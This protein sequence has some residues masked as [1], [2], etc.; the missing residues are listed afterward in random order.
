MCMDRPGDWNQA[1]MELGAR[2]CKPA[3]LCAKCPIQ[4]LCKAHAKGLEANLPT[5][6]VLSQTIRLE[7]I[8][9]IPYYNGLFGLKQIP[10]GRWWHGMWEFPRS[11]LTADLESISSLV[12]EGDLEYA[13]TIKYQVTNHKIQMRAELHRS[14]APSGELCW[15]G[16]ESLQRLPMPAP[17]R[18]ALKLA[19]ACLTNPAP[20]DLKA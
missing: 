15:H 11:E 4:E 7:E 5:A 16:P 8:V 6:K 1:L 17:Q 3:P 14:T 10:E 19:Q 13:G 9:W 12:G 2:I 18:R 20:I